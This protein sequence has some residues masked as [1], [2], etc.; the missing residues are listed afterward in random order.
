MSS[1][2]AEDWETVE[3][4]VSIAHFKSTSAAG[5]HPCF[6]KIIAPTDPHICQSRRL[7][8]PVW[9]ETSIQS[10]WKI[11]DSPAPF[12]SLNDSVIKLLYR[13]KN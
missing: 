1:S 12:E 2:T 6:E 9:A 4:H 3:L 5:P 13:P 10:Y 8:R 7:L 11:T